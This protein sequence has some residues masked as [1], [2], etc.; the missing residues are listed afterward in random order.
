MTESM[1]IEELKNY[2]IPSHIVNIWKKDLSHDLLPI[3]EDAV[4]KYGILNWGGNEG[5]PMLYAPT[6]ANDKKSA[7]RQDNNNLLVIAPTSSGKTFI[8]EMAVIA[9]AIH[10]RKTIYLVP[11]RAL[12]DEKYRHFKKL[13]NHYGIDTVISTRDR[14]EDDHNIISGDYDVAVMA[15][16]KFNYFCLKCPRFLDIVSLVI[17]DEMQLINDLKWGPLLESMVNHIDTKNKNIKIIALSAFI[18]NQEALLRWFP[19]RILISYQRP[20]E[21]RKGMVR[22]GVFEYITSKK[23][24]NCKREVFFKPEAVRD[25]YFKD[26]LL[27]TVKHL[28]K[29]GESVL[30]FFATCDETQKWAKWLASQ[31]ESPT[32]SCALEELKEMEE[33]L[34]RDELRETMEKGIAYYNKNLSWEER[35]LIEIY[36]KEGEIRLSVLQASWTWVSAFILRM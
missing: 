29:Q 31:L 34:S 1:K 14:S 15:Y 19:A 18:E 22:D 3:Q 4:K 25:N 33:T 20:V 26:Y 12:A 5:G 6:G 8:G 36:Q 35:N 17:I 2:G 10:L 9:Q 16:E 30:I 27:E 7:L 28:V 24:E 23:K 11:L 32:A 13:Y 21:L